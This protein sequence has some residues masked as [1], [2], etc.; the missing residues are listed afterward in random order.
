MLEALSR[1]AQVLG[2]T[3]INLVEGYPWVWIAL[4]VVT[5]VLLIR[6]QRGGSL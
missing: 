5:L 2:R 4:T 6:R 1:Q 3:V